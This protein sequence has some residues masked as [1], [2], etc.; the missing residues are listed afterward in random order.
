MITR[1]GWALR[2]DR[3]RYT[4]LSALKC[5]CRRGAVCLQGQPLVQYILTDGVKW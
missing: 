4:E 3:V 1:G 2:A 5:T